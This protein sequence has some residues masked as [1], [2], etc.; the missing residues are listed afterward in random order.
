MLKRKTVRRRFNRRKTRR[1]LNFSGGANDPEAVLEAEKEGMLNL[2]IRFD[3][4]RGHDAKI[5]IAIELM[6][7]LATTSELFKKE[8]FRKVVQNKIQEFATDS[9][10]HL[11][12]K[13]T[14]QFAEA[15]DRLAAHLAM[16]E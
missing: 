14:E 1:Q 4:A 12:G 11:H 10:P 2:I 16:F 8:R 9:A 15:H 5:A 7:F 3:T 6:T 13:K